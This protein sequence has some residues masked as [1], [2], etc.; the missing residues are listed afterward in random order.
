MEK[1]KSNIFGKGYGDSHQWIR[2]GTNQVGSDW[3]YKATYYECPCGAR[4]SHPY[5]IIPNIFEAIRQAGV[6]D[7]C[8]LTEENTD[9][10]R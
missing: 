9:E 3:M 10:G 7:K 8:P 4:F 1:N 5:D 2:G 6:A